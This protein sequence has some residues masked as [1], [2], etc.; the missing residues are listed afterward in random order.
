VVACVCALWRLGC[1]LDDYQFCRAA[2]YLLLSRNGRERGATRSKTWT[3]R[4]IVIDVERARRVTSVGGRPFS[5]VDD[6]HFDRTFRGFKAQSE[7]LSQCLRDRDARD[8]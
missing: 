5:L 4:H 3:L 1:V 2:T 7:L 6:D 8:T